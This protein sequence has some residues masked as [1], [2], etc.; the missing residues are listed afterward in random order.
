M[1]DNPWG[2]WLTRFRT[3]AAPM[4]KKLADYQYYMQHE[5][6]KAKVTAEYDKQSAG[7]KPADRLKLHAR[8][9]RELFLA[10]PQELQTR[11]KEEADA[12]HAALIEKHE[13]ALEGLPAHNEEGLEEYVQHLSRETW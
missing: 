8:V 1:R 10:E 11:M 7:V 13:D 2:E 3:P 6:Y 12:T 5:D 4:P 9:A